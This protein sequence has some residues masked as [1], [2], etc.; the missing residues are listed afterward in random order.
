MSNFSPPVFVKDFFLPLLS[1]LTSSCSHRNGSF[2]QNFSLSFYLRLSFFL[3]LSPSLFLSNFSLF[4]PHSLP[5]TLTSIIHYSV[6]GPDTFITH[7]FFSPL[8][9]N[10]FLIFILSLSLSL[11]CFRTTS[12]W[13]NNELVPFFWLKNSF[14]PKVHTLPLSLSIYVDLFLSLSLSSFFFDSIPFLSLFN[15]KTRRKED[16]IVTKVNIELEFQRISP[17]NR[18]LV[19]SNSLSFSVLFLRK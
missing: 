7:E 2:D 11:F 19:L 16:R 14:S 6:L 10:S 15:S 4:L 3:F 17:R 13:N 5:L 9:F 18:T 8:N 12:I 1:S